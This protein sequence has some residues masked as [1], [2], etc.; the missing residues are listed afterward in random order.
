[1]LAALLTAGSVMLKVV[2]AALPALFV[3]RDG[4]NLMVMPDSAMYNHSDCRRFSGGDIEMLVSS[5]S[6]VSD[7]NH[8]QQMHKQYIRPETQHVTFFCTF[9]AFLNIISIT[10][11][12]N[13]YALKINTIKSKLS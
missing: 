1:M 6:S 11:D 7:P 12:T 4:C 8:L 9:Q 3:K 2:K 5:S 10:A 13:K